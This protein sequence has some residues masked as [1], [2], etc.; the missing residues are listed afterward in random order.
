MDEDS[1]SVPS[2]AFRLLSRVMAWCCSGLFLTWLTDS[3][4]CDSISIVGFVYGV[5]FLI[6]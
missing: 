3:C 4:S 6:D 1:W 5:L 2:P